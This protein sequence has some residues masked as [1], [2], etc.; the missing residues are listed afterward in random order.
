[1]APPHALGPLPYHHA[2]VDYLKTEE[3]ALWDWFASARA[4][5]DYTASLRLALLKSTYRLDADAHPD[6]YRAA[7]GARAAL[8]LD[9]PLTIYQAQQSGALNAA[10]YFIPTE[11]HLVLTGPLL[12]LLDPVETGAVLGHELAHHVLWRAADGD[13]LVADRIVQAIADDPRAAPSHAQTARRYRLYTEIFADRGGV[14]VGGGVEPMVAALVKM[15]TGLPQVSAA[16]YLRQADDIFSGRAPVKAADTSHPE[17]FIRAR[18][19]RLWA[20]GAADVEAAIA[21]MIEGDVALDELDL[22]DQR[23]LTQLTRRLVEQLLRPAWFRTDAV[24]GHAALFF[25]DVRPAGA[26]DPGLPAALRFEDLRL[27]EYLCYVLL[28]FAAAD[29]ELDE[30]PLAATWEW[31][32]RLGL[33]APFEKLL[34]SELGLKPRALKRLT[35]QAAEML[36]RVEA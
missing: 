22:L 32:R 26:D 3:R 11:A 30:L 10:L 33:D 1:M 4:R 16:S 27:R 12:A 8:G 21:A 20:E 36:G 13:F 31:S 18:A 25:T 23:R 6:L 9:V 29:P 34:V 24:L 2:V 7:E 5:E 15:H 35:Q 19:L 28:D 14:R 17:D